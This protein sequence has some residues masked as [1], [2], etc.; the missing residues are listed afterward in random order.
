MSIRTICLFCFFSVLV[1]FNAY[2]QDPGPGSVT[3]FSEEGENFTLY[4][5]GEQKNASP[6]SRVVVE[7]VT[8]VRVSFRIVF[9]DAIPELKKSG[10]RQGANCLFSIQKNKK[11][12]R[13][14]RMKD[15]REGGAV[16]DGQAV[17]QDNAPVQ[18]EATPVSSPEQLSAR[19]AD[20]TITIND[21]R[22]LSVKKLRPTA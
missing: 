1:L 18:R 7:N 17:Q 12:E 10:F 3:V 2:A 4:L 15:C 19:Y 5:N 6:A 22:T 8:E 16:A 9:Q 14:L 21:G 13:V 11:G 20:G